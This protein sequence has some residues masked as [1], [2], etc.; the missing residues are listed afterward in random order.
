MKH[1]QLIHKLS[2]PQLYHAK[3]GCKIR[4]Y[5]H[6]TEDGN[7]IIDPNQYTFTGYEIDPEDESVCDKEDHVNFPIPDLILISF[8]NLLCGRPI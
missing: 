1:Y 8:R 5:I 2:F 3:I 7:G 6:C 4:V